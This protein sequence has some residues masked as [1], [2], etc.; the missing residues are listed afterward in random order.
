[1]NS[2]LVKLVLGYLKDTKISKLIIHTLLVGVLCVILSFCYVIAFH[3]TNL[4]S[5][6][7]EAH[8]IRNFGNNLNGNMK[9]DAHLEEILKRTLAETR[10]NLFLALGVESFV[11]A[12]LLLW[13]FCH[14]VAFN[15]TIDNLYGAL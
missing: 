2:E 3:F 1:M 9:A 7:S 14:K 5:I 12:H 11:W 10:A 15:P 8:S 6:Y 13:V 4:L